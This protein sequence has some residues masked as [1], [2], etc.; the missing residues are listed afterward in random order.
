MMPGITINAGPDERR[1]RYHILLL[2][3]AGLLTEVG[4]GTFRITNSGHDYL[5]AIRDEGIWSKT[6]AVVAETG[7]STTLELVKK[8][9]MGF[10]NAKIE[11]YTGMKL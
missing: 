3:D 5:E 6:K 9:A 7:G 4:K 10:L 8:L 1:E 2:I 11:H